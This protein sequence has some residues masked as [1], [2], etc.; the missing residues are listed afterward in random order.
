MPKAAVLGPIRDAF[1]LYIR[2]ATADCREELLDVCQGAS[3]LEGKN[4]VLRKRIKELEEA[5]QLK[6]SLVDRRDLY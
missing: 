1:E 2:G 4:H 3:A 5:F 6:Q